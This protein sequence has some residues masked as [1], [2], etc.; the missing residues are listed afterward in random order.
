MQAIKL[1]GVEVNNLQKI[2]LDIP[3]CQTVVFCG[4]S[5]SGKTSLA[6]DTLYAEG[7][8]RYIESF[9][10]YTRQFLEQLPQ[11]AAEKIEGIPA[12]IAVTPKQASRSNRVTVAT[13]TDIAQYLQ[14]L[15]AK[16]GT[17]RCTGCGRKVTVE[18]PETAAAWVARQA[19]GMKLIVAFPLS[20]GNADHVKERIAQ[21][22]ADGFVRAV[23]GD[24]IKQLDDLSDGIESEEDQSGVLDVIV[25]RIK[26]GQ[27]Q[28]KR[29]RDSLETAFVQ[30]NGTCCLW[31][32]T[33]IDEPTSDLTLI[34]RTPMRRVGF[35]EQ[36]GCAD[37]QLDFPTGDPRYF[38]FNNSLG[39]CPGCEGFG[40]VAEVDM[41]LVV[42]D[43]HKTLREG[44]I[45][46]WSTPAYSHE[47]QELLDLADDYQ[48]P[49]DVPFADLPDR[50][51]ALIEQGVPERDFGGLRGFFRWLESRKY[52]MPI[53]VFLSRWKTYRRCI[54]CGGSRLKDRVLATTVANCHIAEIMAMSVSDAHYFFQQTDVDPGEHRVAKRI[55]AEVNSRLRY[56][57]SVGLGY[58]TL[59]R[60]LRT[61]SAGESQRV[62][63]TAALGSN[64][65]NM[66]YVLDEPSVGLHPHDIGPL[67]KAIN[68]LRDRSNTVAVIEHQ[69]SVIRSADRVV[70]IGPGAGE[71]GGN[72]VFEGT[73]AELEADE[74]SLTGDY[75]AGR[76]G[77]RATPDP[78][79][80]DQGWIR[81]TGASG[82]N[83]KHVDV[84]FPLGVLCVVTGV[85]G[86]GKSSLVQE[87]LFPALCSR[88]SKESSAGLPY[89]DLLGAG[90]LDD[91]VF[92]DQQPIG[93]SPR[94]NPVTYIKAFDEIRRVFAQATDARVRN[95]TMSHFSFNVEGGRCPRCKGE[96]QI[97][98][99]M[100]FLAD[101][102]MTCPECQGT[103]YRAEV[104]EILYRGR[105]IAEVLDLT[106]REAFVFFRGETKVQ[107]KLKR[108]IDV[109]L[110]YL[111]LGQGA[112]TLSGGEAQ[113]LKM[114]TAISARSQNRTLYILDEP[115][116]GLHFADVAQL[117]DC[118]T[119][120]IDVGH[121]LIVVDHNLQ[122]IKEADYLIDL[123]PGA[124]DAGGEVVGVGTPEE[125]AKHSPHPTARCLAEALQAS[126]QASKIH[127]E[128][129]QLLD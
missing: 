67:L 127:H 90:Q 107:A 4:V 55:L 120:L 49:L 75:L 45:A 80:T 73:P 81:L 89:Q 122:L 54:T 31:L 5:G 92:L 50:V 86:A 78:R 33:N 93:K 24:S 114:A 85:S 41:D 63:L 70:E 123:G 17:T 126:N 98:I 28:V 53:R 65:V 30:G 51:I 99:D 101:I 9:S 100:Q 8:R 35:S 57:E 128:D 19:T 48:I 87:T 18:D 26:T 72:I 71:Q 108:L 39:A 47:L 116:T 29:L 69:E 124:A 52:K 88:L 32:Q 27:V 1:R 44:P 79:P 16:I 119:A 46:P 96:G 117:I 91:C 82:N 118:F 84:D 59:D 12:S 111:P 61:L 112:N 42:P 104:L 13:A 129:A 97:N 2:D 83:L 94:S 25:D 23:V 105:N 113:R 115:T 110:G 40:T 66:L 76:R 7:Q 11:P 37:C 102:Y 38:N 121:S 106:V 22:R 56:L 43:K 20:F 125:L 103:R 36:M 6:L 21:L 15:F 109:G 68:D 34:D 10:P 95:I 60:P 62:A 64:L 3:L 14:L 77:A 58:L 74:G